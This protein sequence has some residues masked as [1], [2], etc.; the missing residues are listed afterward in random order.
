MAKG[1]KKAVLYRAAK[2]PIYPT[3]QQEELLL[4][5]SENLRLVW[6]QALS[7]RMLA[8]ASYRKQKVLRYT[9]IASAIAEAL[10]DTPATAIKMPTLFDQINALTQK[11]ENEKFGATPRNWQEETLDRLDGSFKSFFSLVK[12]GDVNARPP[13]E[14]SQNFFQVIPGRSGFA[15]KNGFIEFASNIFGKGALRFKIPKYQQELLATG[16]SK[17]FVIARDIADLSKESGWSI[18]VVYEVPQPKSLPQEAE[19]VAYL[20][21]GA[22]SV[23]IVGNGVE[24]VL[25]FWRPDKHWKEKAE[26]IEARIK[27][28]NLVKGSLAW[29]RLMAARKK[30]FGLMREQQ[31]QNHREMV[32]R[33]LRVGSHFVVTDYVVRSKQ[34]KLADGGDSDRSGSTGLN[35]AA[36]NTG[37][38]L[39]FV[40]H[41]EEKVKEV[42]GSVRKH[43]LITSPPRGIGIGHCNKIAMAKHLRS[44]F[45][46]V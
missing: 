5:I 12:N 20:A 15:V 1:E 11:R 26:E 43:R 46:G 23:G 45:L 19:K 40:M 17:K 13:R 16:T 32:A 36:Q 35:W 24:L 4:E 39:D 44:E 42:G 37:S 6:N 30:I 28:S 22:S 8:L 33:L 29:K 27:K 10:G 31:R 41:L 3:I 2:F 21:L 25:P 14:R 7:E 38:F 18:S 34:G 9:V